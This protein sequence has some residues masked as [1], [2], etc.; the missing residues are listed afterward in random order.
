M[1]THVLKIILVVI[2]AG[3]ANNAF[4]I[5]LKTAKTVTGLTVLA[6]LCG[7]YKLRNDCFP[8]THFG[9]FACASAVISLGAYY[10]LYQYTPE[11]RMYRASLL[12]DDI[13]Q[14]KLATN[15]FTQEHVF[16]DILH[17]LYITNDLPLISAYNALT[18]IL[19]HAH[20]A[21]KLLQKAQAEIGDNYELADKCEA[22]LSEAQY[23]LSNIINSIKMVRNHKD[24]LEQLRIYKQF[25]ASEKQSEIQEHMVAVQQ[26]MAHAQGQIAH[27]Q[28]SSV[29]LKWMKVLFGLG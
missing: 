7:S 27:A 1:K 13:S 8:Q 18:A 12:L 21:L 22:L 17:E 14:Y 10:T 6:S 24:Y 5:K 4:T 25:L 15:N 9:Y 16:F 19:P 11:G 2:F 29:F 26:Q 3:S 23:V 20:C 28:Q